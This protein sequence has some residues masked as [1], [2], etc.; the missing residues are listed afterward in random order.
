MRRNVRRLNREVNDGQPNHQHVVENGKD[1]AVTVDAAAAGQRKGRSR[2]AANLA[3]QSPLPLPDPSL[4][5]PGRPLPCACMH[6]L[7]SHVHER[8]RSVRPTASTASLDVC[9][10][11]PH[12]THVTA[13]TELQRYF[14]AA[15]DAAAEILN[16]NATGPAEIDSPGSPSTAAAGAV[17]P[18]AAVPPS[19]A[20]VVAAPP[21]VS[22]VAPAGAGMGVV[23]VGVAPPGM[24]GRPLAAGLPAAAAGRA[25]GPV[26]G[27]PV[28][29]APLAP[30]GPLAAPRPPIALA[31][32]S[33]VPGMAGPNAGQQMQMQLQLPLHAHSAAAAAAAAGGQAPLVHGRALPA[34]GAPPH[35]A[36]MPHSSMAG[37]MAAAPSSVGMLSN[38]VGHAGHSA[39]ATASHFQSIAQPQPSLS[40]TAMGQAMGAQAQADS[41][42]VSMVK[43]EPADSTE[44]EQKAYDELVQLAQGGN[45][46]LDS[47]RYEV[48]R[49]NGRRG[50]C[51][52]SRS[53]C[54]RSGARWRRTCGVEGTTTPLHVLDTLPTPRPTSCAVSERLSRVSHGWRWRWCSRVV[55][56]SRPPNPPP[57]CPLRPLPPIIA[58][59]W[60]P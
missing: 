16:E 49:L 3:G 25:A 12:T 45:K 9:E 10:R 52:K 37:M 6:P 23:G 24:G 54:Y 30:A 34:H 44:S 39:A 36:G 41:S 28:P 42:A 19:A 1:Q 32:L 21:P 29:P 18:P 14:T 17:P 38:V 22:V 60:S 15:A 40:G 33:V 13:R 47:P 27:A 11:R 5:C 48:T 50:I 31:Q 35:L 43:S 59:G 56:Y 20:A 51:Q 7:S 58:A 8:R 46:P 57:S 4:F 53:E 55:P 2:K 26:A